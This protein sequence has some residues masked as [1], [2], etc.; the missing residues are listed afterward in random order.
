MGRTL[1]QR[2]AVVARLNRKELELAPAVK[3][4]FTRHHRAN[5]SRTDG[6]RQ[7]GASLQR[8]ARPLFAVFAIAI[9]RARTTCS[10]SE[11]SD[12][13]VRF[14]NGRSTQDR[15]EPDRARCG[16]AA[17][18]DKPRQ[19]TRCR[20]DGSAYGRAEEDLS[21]QAVG[22][23]SSRRRTPLRRRSQMNYSIRYKNAKGI[24]SRSEFLPFDTDS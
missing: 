16:E 3:N 4:R 12:V 18:K 10:V 6:P 5:R 19:Q 24:T 23:H 9:G 11:S 15:A 13:P 8:I 2:S 1:P 21:R 14:K 20:R 22:K 17:G 7:S